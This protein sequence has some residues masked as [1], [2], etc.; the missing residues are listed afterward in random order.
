MRRSLLAN[1]PRDGFEGIFETE[2]QRPRRNTE[3]GE[4]LLCAL[5]VSALKG[6]SHRR[7]ESN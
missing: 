4:A 6:G 5:W 2:T 3:D 1:T 7:P